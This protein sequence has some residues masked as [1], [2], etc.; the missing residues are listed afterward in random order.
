MHDFER[1][2]ITEWRR[3]ELPV[4]GKIVVAVSGG[5]DSVAL[6]TALEKLSADGKINLDITAAHFNHRL[7]GDESDADEAFIRRLAASMEIPLAVGHMKGAGPGNLEQNARDARYD[8]LQS[9]S[10]NINAFALATGHTLNDQAETF[11]QNLM[12]GSGLKGLGAMSP[13]RA[14]HDGGDEGGFL[15]VR[16]LLSWCL[17][18]ETELYCLSRN[19]DFRYDS[20]NEDLRFNRVRI[21][22]VLLPM[23]KDFNPQ[24][25]QTLGRTAELIRSQNQG[26]PKVFEI[27]ENP[28]VSELKIMAE[29]DLETFL[30]EW[31]GTRRGGLRG[32]GRAH[33]T[34]IANLVRSEKSGRIVELPGNAKVVKN[35]GRLIY[36]VEMV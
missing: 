8:F 7:R 20:M 1:K 16:P 30:R 32:V 31:V 36:T 13:S 10:E 33:I 26:Q 2:L 3:L 34:A 29:S 12:R 27:P 18:E 14:F 23:L 17:R 24:I 11:L 15:L 4:E 19:I 9:V 21:R 25:L 22:K 6:L 35:R 5:A 28:K